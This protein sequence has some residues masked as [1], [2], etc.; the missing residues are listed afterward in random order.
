VA[1]PSPDLNPIELVWDEMEREKCRR[2]PKNETEL[3]EVIQDVWENFDPAKLRKL[4]ERIPRVLQAV[5][6]AEGGYFGEK[7]APRKFKK[8]L[9]YH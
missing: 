7:Y 3:V 6:E 8:Q 9:V 2:R 1:F 4:V 5:I